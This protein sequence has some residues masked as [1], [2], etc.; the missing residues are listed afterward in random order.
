MVKIKNIKISGD[1]I[2]C[3]YYPENTNLRGYIA[4]NVKTD[5]IEQYEPSQYYANGRVYTSHVV[6]KLRELYKN[7]D[8]IP[9][10][11]YSVWY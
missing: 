1:I 7:E 6:W 2:S 9:A 5:E 10:E 4:Y 8:E 11:A 3:D